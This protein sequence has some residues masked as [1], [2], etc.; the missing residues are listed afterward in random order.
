ME[1]HPEVVLS[2]AKDG[3]DV[4]AIYDRLRSEAE[5]LGEN[6]YHEL[7]DRHQQ[8]LKREKDKGEYAFQMRREALGRLGLSQVRQH[9]EA[10]GGRYPS[11]G[12]RIAQAGA[13]HAR[14]AAVL[15]I[16]VQPTAETNSV[17][18]PELVFDLVP[19]VD[20]AEFTAPGKR[21]AIGSIMSRGAA[22]TWMKMI[23]R[24]GATGRISL[25]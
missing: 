14:N 8:R 25:F 13:D 19:R 2:G 21:M 15:I 11:L 20:A 4:R 12:R 10:T 3:D 24:V 22:C 9:R 5:R 23:P 6:A 1:D 16:R 18:K 17:A 7:F